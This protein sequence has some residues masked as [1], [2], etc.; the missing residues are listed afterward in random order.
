M[1]GNPEFRRNLWLEFSTH[2]LVAMPAVLLVIVLAVNT[3]MGGSGSRAVA[4]TVVWVMVVIAWLWGTKRA[5]DSVNEELRGRTWDLQ[6][7]SALSPW[8]MMAGKLFG[9]TAFTWY[10]ALICIAILLAATP[11]ETLPQA[12]R[13]ALIV[14]AGGIALQGAAMAASL[15]L[16]QKDGTASPRLGLLLVVAIVMMGGVPTG[17]VSPEQG[18]AIAW[19]SQPIPMHDFMLGSALAFAAWGVFAAWRMMGRALLVRTVPWA[20]AA[21]GVFLAVYFAGLV[22]YGAPDAPTPFVAIVAIGVPV[23]LGLFY[24]LLFSEPTGAMTVRRLLL[25][26]RAAQWPRA[27]QEL[28]AWP[29][30]LAMLALLS[31]AG[32]A[33]FDDLMRVLEK[34]FPGAPLLPL[35]LTAMAVRDAA[36]FLFFSFAPR[37]RRVEMTTLLYLVLL[38]WLVPALLKGF[39]MA[40]LAGLVMPLASGEG[41]RALLVMGVQAAIAVALA[42]WRWRRHYG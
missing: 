20:T 16:V 27:L 40:F 24:I 30:A 21:F 28:P 3:L 17:L 12:V 18:R 23:S 39:G 7:L 36:I 25:R 35:A 15:Q 9:A 38:D 10:G 34:T 22:P 5:A 1:M 31:L 11:F 26:A 37:P 8:D 4:A 42:L 14:I 32:A 6:R 41:T 19:F 2:R 33:L 13:T 29:V